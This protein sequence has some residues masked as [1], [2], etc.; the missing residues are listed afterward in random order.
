MAIFC[1]QC[2]Q[3]IRYGRPIRGLC[4][5]HGKLLTVCI[6]CIEPVFEHRIEPPEPKP[7]QLIVV[8]RVVSDIDPT[9]GYTFAELTPEKTLYA[10]PDEKAHEFLPRVALELIGEKQPGR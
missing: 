5:G 9:G 6:E 7:G 8:K 4:D 1:H 2:E 10:I 3:P